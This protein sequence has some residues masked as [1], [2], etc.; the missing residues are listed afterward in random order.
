ML[1]KFSFFIY[2]YFEV[3][4]GNNMEIF[5]L[6]DKVEY[7]CEVMELEHF[8]WGENP[9][10]NLEQRL[11]RKV[12]K[13]Y[14][15]V[16]NIYFCKLILLDKERLVGF[17]SIFPDDCEECPELTPWYATMYVKKEYRGKGYSKILN[18]AILEEAKRRGIKEIYLKTTLKNYYEKF[19]AKVL[20]NITDEEKL[21]KFEL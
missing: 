16:D 7:L 5:N 4:W 20:K 8:E 14:D 17:I 19:G 18:A 13:F 3:F 15:N 2:N 11:A 1:V 6:K 10:V 12:K 9:E 21:L